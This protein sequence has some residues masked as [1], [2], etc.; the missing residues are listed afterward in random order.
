M[1]IR[2]KLTADD[3]RAEGQKVTAEFK[4]WLD[5]GGP[6]PGPIALVPISGF[7]PSFAFSQAWVPLY[8]F[9]GCVSLCLLSHF[10]L[11]CECWTAPA[12]GLWV[13]PHAWG[14]A[15]GKRLAIGGRPHGKSRCAGCVRKAWALHAAV[16]GA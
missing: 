6:W 11:G 5:A 10:S 2:V 13:R 14:L 8:A 7:R 3:V 16:P 1:E 12:E 9:S 15:Q 4:K